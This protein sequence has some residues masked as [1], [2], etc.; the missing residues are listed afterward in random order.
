M[1]INIVDP[2]FQTNIFIGIFLILFLVSNKLAKTSEGLS[3]EVT[4]E[5]KGAAI[6]MV[7]FCHAGY[8][9]FKDTRFLYPL[10]INGGVGVNVFLFL[11]GFGLTVSALS[12]KLSVLEFYKKRLITI[13]IPLWIVLTILMLLDYLVLHK[14]Y[15]LTYIFTSFVGFY[16]D[17]DIFKTVNSPLWYFSWIVFYYICLPWIFSKKFPLISPLAIFIL[18]VL[19]LKLTLPIKADVHKLYELHTWGFPLGM[20]AAI[21]SKQIITLNKRLPSIFRGIL[22]LG[23]LLVFCYYS[24][25]SGVGTTIFKEQFFSIITTL[26]LVVFAIVKPFRSG[27]L[28]IIGKYS[29]EIYLIHW[30]LMYRYDLI[31][32]YLPAGVGTLIYLIVLV[33]LGFLLQEICKK[34][35]GLRFFHKPSIRN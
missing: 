11:S 4:Q 19:F 7:V 2:L 10:S 32:K 3:I 25:N 20:L 16:P 21:F 14:T 18:S 17:A 26:A 29:Y 6:L 33:G 8:F 31:Y 23:G 12:K 27:L 30:P 28:K 15:S 35:E 22:L 34:I 5:L 13:F 24:L 1:Q 9:L